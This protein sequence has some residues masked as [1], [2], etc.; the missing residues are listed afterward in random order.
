METINPP[1]EGRKI[2]PSPLTVLP[3]A[4]LLGMLAGLGLAIAREVLDKRFRS[5]AELEGWFGLELLAVV[6]HE[7]QAVS[8]RLALPGKPRISLLLSTAHR[9]RSA[10]AEAYRSLRNTLSLSAHGTPTRVIQITSTN[11]SEGKS[12]LTANLGIALAQCGKRV[13]LVDADLYHPTLQQLFGIE[14]ELGLTA[15]L[16]GQADPADAISDCGIAG[17]SLLTSGSLPADPG[18]LLATARFPEL[19]DALREQYDFILLD[20][21]PVLAVSDTTAVAARV[22]GVLFALQ[23]AQSNRSSAEQAI[24]A[25]AAVGATILGVVI[26]GASPRT[27]SAYCTPRPLT[28]MSNGTQGPIDLIPTA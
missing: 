2:A 16:D 20:T 8:K 23:I 28:P 12:V 1:A 7:K 26:T 9:P 22:D 17:L 21:P 27:P 13:L 6:P 4:A 11:R 19:L 3:P 25:L 15:L 18:E 14:S 10:E 24:Q 5:P